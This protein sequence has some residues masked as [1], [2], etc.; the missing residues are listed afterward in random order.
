MKEIIVNIN[1]LKIETEELELGAAKYMA[2][3]FMGKLMDMDMGMRPEFQL[4]F[5]AYLQSLINEFF[6]EMKR[7]VKQQE[8]G[9]IE[10]HYFV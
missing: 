6:G 8:D 3:Q 9:S 5:L 4:I 7:V 1:G 10:I 2:N